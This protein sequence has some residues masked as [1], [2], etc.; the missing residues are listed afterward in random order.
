MDV[1]LN[2]SNDNYFMDWRNFKCNVPGFYLMF[3]RLEMSDTVDYVG[4]YKNKKLLSFSKPWL[5]VNDINDLEKFI[6]RPTYQVSMMAATELQTGDDLDINSVPYGYTP[7][8]V[9]ACL[10]IIKI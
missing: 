5:S 9:A 7:S 4:L 2:S 10:T 3:L 6:Q 8:D 1:V